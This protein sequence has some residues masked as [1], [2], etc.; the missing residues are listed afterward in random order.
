MS[1]RKRPTVRVVV[2]P[3]TAEQQRQCAL[4]T[5][6]LLAD[7]V[8]NLIEKANRRNHDP[9]RPERKTIHRSVAVQ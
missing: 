6:L 1:Q 7:I 8:R 4:A 2:R 9:N 5:D 3:Q